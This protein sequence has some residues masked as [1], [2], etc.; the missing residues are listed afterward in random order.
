M[1]RAT[2]GED[3]KQS[4]EDSLNSLGK[5]K[6]NLTNTSPYPGS[7]VVQAAPSP[8]LAGGCQRLFTE[9]PAALVLPPTPAQSLQGS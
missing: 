1:R 4:R 2:G 9:F 5:V 7:Q 8:L 6:S 3:G